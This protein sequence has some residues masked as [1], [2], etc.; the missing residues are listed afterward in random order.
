M[1]LPASCAEALLRAANRL[2]VWEA[3]A[4]A[5][6]P[7]EVGPVGLKPVTRQGRLPAGAKAMSSAERQRR[8]HERLK[9]KQTQA[10]EVE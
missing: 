7:L 4:R 6:Q 1:S 8:Y 2:C 10:E 9:T 5:G 3:Q